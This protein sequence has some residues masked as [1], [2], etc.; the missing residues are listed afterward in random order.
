MLSKFKI[1]SVSENSFSSRFK[2]YPRT[3][4]EPTQVPLIEV[5]EAEVRRLRAENNF[6][7]TQY[8]SMFVKLNTADNQ[9]QQA[10]AQISHLQQKMVP[11][12]STKKDFWQLGRSGRNKKKEDWDNLSSNQLRD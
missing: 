2:V 7:K 12:Y 3:N 8:N 6:L 4:S 9:L 1:T 11:F 10:N 5:Y